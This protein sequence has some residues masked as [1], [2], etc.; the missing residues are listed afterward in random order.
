[1]RPNK[2][3][4]VTATLVLALFTAQPAAAQLEH[5]PEPDPSPPGPQTT[6]DAD[7]TYA[8]GVDIAPGT[9]RSAGPIADG[10]C[11]WK[12]VNGSEI[13]EN[14]LSKKPQ[15]VR[16]EPTDSSFVTNDCQ[17]WELT[18]C[19]PE[20]GTP[21]APPHDVLGAV[22]GFLAPRL[23]GPPPTGPP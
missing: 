2:T 16:I 12:R 10:A 21:T 17:Q 7:G 9:Y 11:Y 15:L 13:V 19:G 8:V 5:E 22:L 14:A 6:I 3:A 4:A 23:A 1:M 18:E 20:C